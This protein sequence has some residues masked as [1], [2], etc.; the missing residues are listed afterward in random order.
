MFKNFIFSNIII[1]IL[2]G[3]NSNPDKKDTA[4]SYLNESDDK[5]NE[6]VIIRGT[7]DDTKALQFVDVIDGT[8]YFGKNRGDLEKQSGD[9]LLLV[10]NNIKENQFSEF[11]A[12]SDSNYYKA[13]IYMAPGDS[14]NFKIQDGK[15]RFFG[16]HATVNN[17]FI[18]LD[19]KTKSYNYNSYNGNLNSYKENVELI[20]KEKLNF[21][22]EYVQKYNITSGRELGFIKDDLKQEYMYELMNPRSKLIELPEIKRIMYGHEIDGINFLISKEYGQKET[23]FSGEK[24][25]NNVSFKDIN[26]PELLYNRQFREN[27]N[28]Y[29]RNYFEN[30]S[31]TN[32]SKEKFIAEKKFIENKLDKRLVDFALGELIYDYY[33]KGFGYGKENSD[34]LIRMISEYE[35][36]NDNNQ[37]QDFTSIKKDLGKYNYTLPKSALESK[38]V[39]HKGDTTSLKEIFARS[40]RRIKVLD[41]WASWCPPCIIQIRDNKDF[42]DRLSVENNV[43]WIYLSIDNNQD[44]WKKKSVELNNSLNFYNSFWLIEGKNSALAK[45]LQINTIPRY[46]IFDQSNQIILNNAPIPNKQGQFE[47]IIDNI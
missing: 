9:S 25:F 19:E 42:K 26:R 16:D 24:Y 20:Y 45:F 33:I 13:K 18:E 15:I 4:S 47:K 30:S 11:T 44:S 22:N 46:I 23:F 12:A 37:K 43:E 1:F 39:N 34:F 31:N 29:I 17:F 2:L 8:Y 5:N 6:P 27:L 3:C 14:L 7:A 38:M 28:L 21:L 41:F 35:E 36:R 40:T 10:L 32:Y